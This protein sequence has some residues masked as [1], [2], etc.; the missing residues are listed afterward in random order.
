MAL[1]KAE[2]CRCYDLLI[3]FYII[4]FVLDYKIICILLIIENTMG[5]PHLKN[6]YISFK[7]IPVMQ[8]LQNRDLNSDK[9]TLCISLNFTQFLVPDDDLLSGR[10]MLYW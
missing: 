3:T 5:M 8:T 4:K 7:T 10:N 1:W 2:T 9:A 6:R